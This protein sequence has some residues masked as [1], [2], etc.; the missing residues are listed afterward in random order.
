MFDRIKKSII[1]KETIENKS[2]KYSKNGVSLSFTLRIDTKKE[3][4]D[5]I[6]ILK[7][8]QSDLENQIS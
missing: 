2:F 4:I 8:A 1:Q 6:E 3:I 7:Q 5:F